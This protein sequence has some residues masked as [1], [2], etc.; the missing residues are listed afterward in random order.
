MNYSSI[1]AAFSVLAEVDPVF[2]VVLEVVSFSELATALANSEHISEELLE[3][4][5]RVDEILERLD[6]LAN[7]MLEN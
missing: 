3:C 5:L 7:D 6:G 1:M 4:Q 2:A